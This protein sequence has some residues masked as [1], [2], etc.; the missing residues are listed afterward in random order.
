MNRPDAIEKELSANDS[1]ETGTH[2]AGILIARD[3]RILSFFPPLDRSTKNPRHS[4][5]FRDS[6][7]V[8]WTFEFIYYNNRFFGG[9]RN[10]YRLTCMTKYLRAENLRAGDVV[11]LRREEGAR[12]F[13]EARRKKAEVLEQG[14]LKLGGSW[15]VVDL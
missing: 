6:S 11:V 7:G 15:K 3:E 1:G 8:P 13:V 9:T 10:E 12:Y 2:Q 5:V 4:I 14:R